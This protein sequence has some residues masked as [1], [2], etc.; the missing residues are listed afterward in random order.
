VAVKINRALISVSNKI[1]IVKFA[2]VLQ[3]MG[4]EIVSTGGTYK[5][6]SESGIKVLKVEELTGFPEMLDGRL[7]TLHPFI[8]GAILADRKKKDHMKQIEDAGI[9][10]I[11]MVVV[12]LYPFKETISRPD[13][14]FEHAIENIDIC[15]PTMIRSAAKNS[16]SVAVIVD[17][18]DYEKV[19]DE[20]SDSGGSLG[21]GTLF[22]LSAKAFQHTCEYD[23]VIF[24][25]MI[26]RYNILKEADF[27]GSKIFVKPYLKI[28]CTKVENEFID[29]A[30]INFFR[31]EKKEF[32]K[33]LNL[34][35]EKKQDLRYGE[36]PHQK[37]AYYKL[38]GAPVES[39]INSQQLQ[40]KELS[41]NNILDANAAF[42]IVREF[43][44]PCVAVIKHNNPC[45]VSTATTVTEA[46]RNAHLCDPVSA[47]GS[48]VACNYKWTSDAARFMIDKFVEV[49]IA[50]DFED[51]ALNI[52][53]TRENL[54]IL[55]ISFRL[56]EY[57]DRLK[58]DIGEK[59]VDIKSVD[60][61]LLVQD[62]D[63]S[64]VGGYSFEA[65]TS[66]KPS[67]SQMDDLIFAWQ[68]VKNVKS[69]AIVLVKNQTTTGIGAGQ[70]SR[71]DATKNAIEKAGDSAKDSVLASDAF[72]PFGDAVE[73]AIDAGVSAIVQPGGSKNDREVIDIC[74]KKKVPMLFT[75]RRHFKH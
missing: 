73:L 44:T 36:N 74:N 72:F 4:I 3:N 33:I 10:S 68:I 62:P 59:S 35:Y 60:G 57:L 13:V 29:S 37:A 2:E 66:L 6:L 41:Y 63:E 70:M 51:E 65:I 42:A 22:N 64:V 47:F 69:N 56:D 67:R 52:L 12:N 19:A 17:P 38:K 23:S 9:K 7:K 28:D 8:H 26:N 54:R 50:P 49:L 34:Y 61:G 75:G 58:N 1:G 30:T 39:F 24:N 46:Y 18:E 16:S 48:V 25:Y 32:N 14:K 31:T 5:Q 71:V 40:G 43:D 20:L 21:E 27:K 53:K 15:G 11:D 45:G 55:K